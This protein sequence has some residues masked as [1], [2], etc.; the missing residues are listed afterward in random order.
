MPQQYGVR[1]HP[2][3]FLDMIFNRNKDEQ[4]S[5]M[6]N[7]E[8]LNETND[9]MQVNEDE[10]DTNINYISDISNEGSQSFI[11]TLIYIYLPS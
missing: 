8:K 4:T 5:V 3:F 11:I 6:L 7:Y 2:L 9:T 1:K 10:E